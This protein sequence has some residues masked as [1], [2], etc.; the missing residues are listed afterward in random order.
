MGNLEN[1]LAKNSALSL[2]L[3]AI[4]FVTRLA[5]GI[6]SRGRRNGD[7]SS[8]F[9]GED[10][11]QS[12][13]LTEIN[14]GTNSGDECISQTSANIETSDSE[15]THKSGGEPVSAMVHNTSDDTVSLC[16]EG[17]QEV[18]HDETA[19]SFKHF[20]TARDPVDHYFLGSNGQVICRLFSKSSKKC[21]S[22]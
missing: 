20:D 18:S 21:S 17:S 2:P 19:S 4:G 13:T 3:A 1:Q 8:D 9:G 6:F 11:N 10:D 22:L 14:K 15:T 12:E 7:D 5:S 16:V